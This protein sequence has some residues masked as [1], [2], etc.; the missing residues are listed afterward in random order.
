VRAQ[1]TSDGLCWLHFANLIKT[2][3]FWEKATSTEELPLLESPLGMF[4]WTFS[5]LMIDVG[6]E[7][8]WR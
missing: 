4:V 5:Q 6:Q 2:V 8:Q 7:G 1:L 3:V